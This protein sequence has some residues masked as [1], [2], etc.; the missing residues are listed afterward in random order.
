MTHQCKILL[1][2]EF[3]IQVVQDVIENALHRLIET[4]YFLMT[5]NVQ[6]KTFTKK[7]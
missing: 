1:K 6:V 2:K 7:I 5:F 3:N 4:H